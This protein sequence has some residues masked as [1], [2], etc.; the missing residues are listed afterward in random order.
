MIC[1]PVHAGDILFR[2]CGR[3]RLKE[4]AGFRTSAQGW[5]CCAV[6]RPRAARADSIAAMASA[7]GTS[8][9]SSSPAL[10]TGNDL[11]RAARARARALR[12]RSRVRREQRRRQDAGHSQSALARR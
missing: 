10:R 9:R 1:Q 6:L 2:E 12:P 11:M 4:A 7:T 3:N 5:G 8:A